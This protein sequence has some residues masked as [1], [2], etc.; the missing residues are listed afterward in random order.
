MALSPDGRQIAYVAASD[1]GPKLWVRRF[2][3]AAA[4][5]LPG[6]DG[7]TYPFW[8]PDSRAIGFFAD[9]KV[10]RIDLSG[11]AP[12]ALADHIGP[13]YSGIAAFAA[14]AL[15]MIVGSLLKPLFV[16]PTLEVTS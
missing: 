6:T 9:G 15:A 3:Q 5:A 1:G 14:A 11:G 10:K 12:Q 8:A 13:W 2:D 4:T 16:P 7:A